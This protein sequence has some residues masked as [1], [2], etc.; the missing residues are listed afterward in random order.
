M[1]T[2]TETPKR[3]AEAVDLERR[4][5]LPGT[6]VPLTDCGEGVIARVM[7]IGF[8]QFITSS[9]AIGRIVSV[10]VRNVTI[11]ERAGRDHEQMASD[12]V[13]SVLP[14]AS[15][16]LL[17]LLADCVTVEFPGGEVKTL[18]EANVPHWHVAEVLQAWAEESFGDPK[19]W[20]PWVTAIE[21]VI[22]GA[23]KKPSFSIKETWSKLS[24]L[25]GTLGKTSSTTSKP[26]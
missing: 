17:S 14:I 2:E 4:A 24:S 5:L 8:K 13:A 16:E 1:T 18:S 15:D 10:V 11:L 7:P 22:R 19:K 21:T 3:T 26:D 25:A 20:R 23:L 12:I 9:K 6:E